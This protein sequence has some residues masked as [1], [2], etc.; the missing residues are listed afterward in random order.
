MRKAIGIMS[1]TSLDGIDIALVSIKGSFTQTKVE[2]I[3]F[4]TY[5]LDNKLKEK[6]QTQLDVNKSNIKI[7]TSLNFEIAIEFS[8][9]VNQ[10]LKEHNLTPNDIDYIASHGQTIYHIP[11]S[12]DGLVPSTLQ[13]GDGSVIANLTNIPTVFNFRTADMAVEGQGA[14]L[15]PY[16]DYVVFSSKTKNRVMLNIGGIANITYLKKDGTIDDVLAFDTGPG[17][18]IINC[19]V[20]HFYNLP[21]DDKGKIASSG[22]IINE[23]LDELMS[24]PYIS[25][26]PPKSTGREKYGI[27][28]SQ[29]LLNKYEKYDKEDLIC[30]VTEFTASSIAK[31]IKLLNINEDDLE[32]IASGGGSHNTYLLKRLQNYLPNAKVTTTNEY[33]LDVDAKEAVAFAV[34]GNETIQGN[35]SNVKSATGAKADVILGQIASPYK[36][37]K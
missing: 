14:P 6:I 37:H 21:Y 27:Q 9:A 13:L 7:L 20:E 4:K 30:T 12:Q 24:D 10:F 33:K 26:L 28:F 31:N 1:G 15:V 29:Y 17:N 36:N 34:L 11:E 25:K 19:F 23:L 5:K 16:Y 3:Q 22:L 18:M 35:Y 32:V 2:L 8:A